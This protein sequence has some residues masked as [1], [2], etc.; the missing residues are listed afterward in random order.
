[1]TLDF[2]DLA[3]KSL[4]DMS[5]A[6]FFYEDGFTK[7]APD[8]IISPDMTLMSGTSEG[9]IFTGP[10]RG[11]YIEGVASYLANGGPFSGAGLIDSVKQKFIANELAS[12]HFLQPGDI[13]RH[14][15]SVLGNIEVAVVQ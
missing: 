13:V 5:E 1:M 6:R 2:R 4:G 14:D 9:V 15:S 10:S 3:I 11:D 7:L 8:G 12:K